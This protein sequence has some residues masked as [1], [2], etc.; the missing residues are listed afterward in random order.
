[1]LDFLCQLLGTNL[2]DSVR[3][4]EVGDTARPESMV[5]GEKNMD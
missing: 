3:S 4:E 1:M 5:R 2:H